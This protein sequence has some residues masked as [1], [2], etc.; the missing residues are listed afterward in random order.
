MIEALLKRESRPQAGKVQSVPTGLPLWLR[1]LAVTD[2]RSYRRSTLS[3]AA[4][5]VVLWGENGAGK[6][7]L[8]EAIS[9]FSPGRGLRGAPLADLALREGQDGAG[10]PGA[11]LS[12]PA[13]R[14]EAWSVSLKV[15][16]P[17]G[18]RDLGTGVTGAEASR[19]RR[20][21]RIDGAPARG[22]AAFAD[23]L[24]IVWLTPQMD[25]L[26]RDSLAVRRRFLDRLVT[27]FDPEH[28]SRTYAYEHALRER[29][30]LLKTGGGDAAWLAALEEAMAG[31]GIAI[32]AARRDLVQRLN[33]AAAAGIGPFPA[34]GLALDCDVERGLAD[35][36]ALVVEERLRA[37]LAELRSRDAEVGGAGVGPHRADLEARHLENAM[38]A[39]LCS[40]GEQ[41]ALLISILLAHARLILLQRGQP[42][43]L[44]LDEVAAHLDGERR[45][46]LFA[47]LFAL[48]GQF[49]V[50]GTEEGVFES[51]RGRAQF[52]EVRDGDVSSG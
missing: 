29:A 45:E 30:R 14:T 21:A 11:E 24:R 3:C 47:E 6:T 25:S 27:S 38:S 35:D 49:W 42:P 22:L 31:Q 50:T 40:T 16:T 10:A 4:R 7:N 5:P 19:E 15:M 28:V 52:F 13:A 1:Q 41:K 34:V 46:A 12:K 20:L 2:F 51:L 32:A 8:L 17:E 44:L 37:R 18:E 36:P 33:Q 26:F 39:T 9:L 23:I 48:G 43:L